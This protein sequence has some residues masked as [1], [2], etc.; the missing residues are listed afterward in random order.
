[1]FLPNRD[2]KPVE[3]RAKSQTWK[4]SPWPASPI[5]SSHQLPHTLPD[6]HRLDFLG[7]EA[8]IASPDSRGLGGQ[9]PVCALRHACAF[10]VEPL[11]AG[12]LTQDGILVIIH[13][14][15]TGATWVHQAWGRL[16][17]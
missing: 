1:M 11:L 8:E 6:V 15:A 2:G 3:T 12:G 14:T 17:A 16:R 7:L 4:P 10:S 13:L 9:Q 5:V